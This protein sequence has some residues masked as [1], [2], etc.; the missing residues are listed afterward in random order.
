MQLVIQA[1][2]LGPRW[3][4]VALR[5]MVLLAQDGVLNSGQIAEKLGTESTFLRKILTRLAKNGLIRTFAGRYGGYELGKP[6]QDI[7][8]GDV[9]KTLINTA[10]TPYYSVPPTGSEQFIS[11]IIGKAERGFQTVLDQYTI[12]DLL[13]NNPQR[14]Y[15]LNDS[16]I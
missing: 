11:L 14:R 1:G 7:L 16:N 9:Y 2:D 8:I 6:P 15:G 3:F 10:P 4:H 5:A 13:L 12:M